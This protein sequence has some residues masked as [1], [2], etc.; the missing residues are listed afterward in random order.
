MAAESWKDEMAKNKKKKSRP[1]LLF[2]QF[3]GER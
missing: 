3:L 1:T 2:A